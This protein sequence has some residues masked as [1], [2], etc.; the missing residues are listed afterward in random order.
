[1]KLLLYFLFFTS[2]TALA[3]N[4]QAI[5]WDDATVNNKLT[6]TI[7]KRDFEAIYKKDYTLTNPTEFETCGT[8]DEANVKM[9]HYKDVTFE[10]DNNMLNFRSIVFDR[11]FTSSF[12]HKGI[13][14]DQNTTWEAFLKTFPDSEKTK[15]TEALADGTYTI[16]TVPETPA[17]GEWEF[18]FK[19]G[20]LAAVH[21]MFSCY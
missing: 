9:L 11:K 17:E 20:K 21:Y 6:L 12:T 15:E 1:M 14:F 10:V 4:N 16:V 2:L 3:Q 7:A 18:R 5:N 19:A 8:P 13:R